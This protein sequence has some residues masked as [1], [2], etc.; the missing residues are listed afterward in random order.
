MVA[1][2]QSLIIDTAGGGTIGVLDYSECSSGRILLPAGVANT[3]L[4]FYE[5]VAKNG[6]FHLCNDV[7]TSG[8]LT[9]PSAAAAAMAVA[10][11]TV[12]AGSKFLKIVAG[13]AITTA[14][15]IKKS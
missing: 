4:T 10:M 15:I 9:V 7:G 1:F 2:V 12:L 5:S 11:P 8:V 13:T 3:E 14:T 6:T